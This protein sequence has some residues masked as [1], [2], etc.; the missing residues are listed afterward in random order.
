MQAFILGI[1]NGAICVAYCSPILIPYLVGEG[2][3]IQRNF[4]LIGQF[5]SGRLAGYLVFAVLAWG[6]NITIFHA[7]GQRE[8]IIGSAYIILS[9]FLVAYGFFH[10]RPSCSAGFLKGSLQKAIDMH[11]AF[12]TAFMGFA[13]GLSFCPPFLLALTGAVEKGS[14]L[15]SIYFFF[16]FF[17]GTSLFFI[18]IP[19]IGVLRRFSVLPVIGKMATG[20]MGIYYFY[21]GVIM[22]AGAVKW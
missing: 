18:P 21:S 11:P 19:F 5:L 6:I 1:S 7:A 10:I 17:L 16:A 12:L 14:L 13:T 15:G 3:N 4:M 8:L 22:L 2:G 9:L 20:I